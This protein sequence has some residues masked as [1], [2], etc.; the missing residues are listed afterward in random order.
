MAVP[1]RFKGLL[2]IGDRVLEI[3]VIAL[4]CLF[5]KIGKLG[6]QAAHKSVTIEG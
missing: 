4:S 1:P 3:T 5:C 6:L 2:S